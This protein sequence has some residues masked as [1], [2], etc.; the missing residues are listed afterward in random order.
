MNRSF[1]YILTESLLY[2]MMLHSWP[3]NIFATYVDVSYLTPC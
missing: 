2:D 3:A 1:G